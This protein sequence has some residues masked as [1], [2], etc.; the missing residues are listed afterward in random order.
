[1]RNRGFFG[2]LE[3]LFGGRRNTEAAQRRQAERQAADR[4]DLRNAGT[5]TWNI[6]V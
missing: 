2:W 4:P 1:M 3:S 6:S 5:D